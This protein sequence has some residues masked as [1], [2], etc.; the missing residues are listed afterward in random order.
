MFFSFKISHFQW[1]QGASVFDPILKFTEW[2]QS[3]RTEFIDDALDNFLLSI[4]CH[5]AETSTDL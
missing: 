4:A 1:I 5:D 3:I 2:I